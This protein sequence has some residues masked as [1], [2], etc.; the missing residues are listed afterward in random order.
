[1]GHRGRPIPHDVARACCRPDL[2]PG[3]PP[4][5]A[6]PATASRSAIAAAPHSSDADLT[7]GRS[8]RALALH[9]LV[10]DARPGVTRHPPV[11]APTPPDTAEATASTARAPREAQVRNRSR[12]RTSNP[13]PKTKRAYTSPS[14]TTT[15]T[16]HGSCDC[17]RA[18]HSCSQDFV[19]SGL[20]GTHVCV[21][22]ARWTGASTNVTRS[23]MNEV[24]HPRARAAVP[25][26][27]C[28][29]ERLPGLGDDPLTIS[30]SPPRPG[31]SPR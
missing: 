14:T 18:H 26:E 8:I 25:T 17:A 19:D 5:P 24:R 20:T 21:D 23:W 6:E 7:S 16:V 15:P 12:A 10:S 27:R 2:P 28:R 3:P 31:R 4:L 1:M 22:H 11:P 29:R 13:E 30:P 9:R